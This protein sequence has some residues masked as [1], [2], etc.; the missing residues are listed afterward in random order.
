MVTGH[1]D[2]A[3]D[4]SGIN[5]VGSLF[6]SDKDFMKKERV[7]QRRSDDDIRGRRFLNYTTHVNPDENSLSFFRRFLC[8]L[9]MLTV[10]FSQSYIIL[11]VQ[12]TTLIMNF[13]YNISIELL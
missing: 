8:D 2:Q 9:Y 10:S 7:M 1:T 12:L 11:V 6:H 4:G 5:Y 3:I 13:T